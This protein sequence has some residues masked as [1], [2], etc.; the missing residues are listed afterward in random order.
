MA[1]AKKM[2]YKAGIR[3]ELRRYTIRGL[4][5]RDLAKYGRDLAIPF[6]FCFNKVGQLLFRTS[7]NS[8]ITQGYWEGYWDDPFC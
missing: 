8:R 6:N 1:I 7:Y 5:G 4:A 3:A 2:Y